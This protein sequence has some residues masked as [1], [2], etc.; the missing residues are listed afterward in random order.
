M[1]DKPEPFVMDGSDGVWARAC[2]YDVT[3]WPPDIECID[4]ETWKITVEYKGRGL[5]GVMRGRA[6][7]DRDGEWAW[8]MAPSER[9]DEWLAAHRFP[10]TDAMRLAR[11]HAPKVTINGMTAVEVLA[12]HR[13]RH[14]DGNC[15]P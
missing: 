14:P 8:E 12:R 13:Q 9:E 1:S 10:I 4:S 11:E 6:C 2:S 15:G 5:W 3:V 7:L